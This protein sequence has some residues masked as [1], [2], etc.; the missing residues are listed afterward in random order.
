MKIQSIYPVLA[1]DKLEET[2]SFY[3]THFPFK[4]SFA[5]EWYVSL[6]SDTEPAHQLA[7]MNARHPSIPEGFR[8]SV[9]GGLLINFEIEDVD[10]A[11]ERM[12]DA[13][14]PIHLELRTEAWGQ[15]H[16]ISADPNGVLIDIIKLIPPSE[17][18]AA[19][20][21]QEALDSFNQP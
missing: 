17:E 18:F 6:I 9:R 1:S 15:R 3:L 19:S 20:Y 8:D 2:T 7:I 5:N 11:Y 12:R 21:S 4:T 13:G 16:F 10:A 14:L